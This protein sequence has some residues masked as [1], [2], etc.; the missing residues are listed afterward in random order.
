MEFLLVL[1]PGVLLI[2]AAWVALYLRDRRLVAVL[3]ARHPDVFVALRGRERRWYDAS[4]EL[5]VQQVAVRRRLR[6]LLQPRLADDPELAAIVAG[7]ERGEWWMRQAAWVAA[8]STALFIV[9]LV[10]RYRLTGGR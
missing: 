5:L 8:G 9:A 10:A 2:D 7:V 1:F 3:R 6:S 4:E